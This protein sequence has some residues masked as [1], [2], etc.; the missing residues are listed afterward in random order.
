MAEV[1]AGYGGAV[2]G[3]AVLMRTVLPVSH[4]LYCGSARLSIAR[5]R[6]RQVWA[7][8]HD[9]SSP[10]VLRK[11]PRRRPHPSRAPQATPRP[12]RGGG[13]GLVF[14]LR[15]AL[16]GHG[17]LRIDS[18]SRTHN[19]RVRLADARGKEVAA[20]PRGCRYCEYEGC[21]LH[22]SKMIRVT[23]RS[24]W[25]NLVQRRQKRRIWRDAVRLASGS[26]ANSL[27]VSVIR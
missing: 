18:A 11:L 27:F 20:H 5:W 9:C 3:S 10:R 4:V 26:T 16:K 12:A 25:P 13:A 2:W 19:V 6:G 21:I 15:G 17:L 24:T 7:C 14:I 1:E 22:K 23:V 8:C